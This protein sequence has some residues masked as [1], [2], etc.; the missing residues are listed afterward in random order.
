MALITD[1]TDLGQL[2]GR[3]FKA[4]LEKSGI[5][6][7]AEEVVPR[8]ATTADAADAEDPRGKPDAMFMAGRADGR[9]TC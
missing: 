6:V 7:V 4:G 1:N 8:G 3:F 2:L 5:Q 9:R